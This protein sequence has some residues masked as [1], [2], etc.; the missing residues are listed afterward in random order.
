M[1]FPGLV[2]PVVS[3]ATIGALRYG[4][5]AIVRVA[6]G[7]TAIMSSGRIKAERALR[8]LRALR[9]ERHQPDDSGPSG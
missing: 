3:T 9:G 1:P 7:L 5:D 6:A 2:V 8:V 4:S